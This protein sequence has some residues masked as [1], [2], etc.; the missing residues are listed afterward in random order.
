MNA[1]FTSYELRYENTHN[2]NTLSKIKKRKNQVGNLKYFNFFGWVHF[3]IKEKRLKKVNLAR[4]RG[5]KWT[6]KQR[7]KERLLNGFRITAW[8]GSWGLGILGKYLKVQI[9]ITTTNNCTLK[10]MKPKHPQWHSEMVIVSTLKKHSRSIRYTLY[11]CEN[12][13]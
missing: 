10:I 8:V 2:I 11:K 13:L 7:E 12:P 4:D 9:T 5:E 3:Q 1:I 6:V